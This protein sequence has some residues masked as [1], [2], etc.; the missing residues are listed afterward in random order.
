M[1]TPNIRLLNC[2]PQIIKHVLSGDETLS[3]ELNLTVPENW[4]TFGYPAFRYALNV[5]ENNP[6][7]AAWWMYLVIHSESQTLIGSCGYKGPPDDLG[8]V[9]IGYEVCAAF[10]NQG[11][12]TEITRQL[13][14]KAF[15]DDRINIVQAHT[16]AEEN[17]SGR[18]LKKNGFRFVEAVEDEE[19]GKV[20]KWEYLP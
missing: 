9:E 16:L 11:I 14:K 6:A 5:I 2:T 15:E 4:S 10:R 19:D 18:V 3:S 12:A 17:A 13:L 20:W 8:V 7:N 1:A